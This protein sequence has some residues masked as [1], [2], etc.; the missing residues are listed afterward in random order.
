MNT[1]RSVLWISLLAASLPAQQLNDDLFFAPGKTRVLILSGRNNHDWRAST[2]HLRRILEA[3]GRFD[4]RVTEEP[5]AL[6]RE[7]LRPYHVLVSDYCGPR[8]SA[9]AEDA[10]ASFVRGGKGLV[11][12]HAA[13]YPFGVMPVL[14]SNM[15]RTDVIQPAWEEWDKML[16]AR[17]Q[18]GDPA[19]GGKRT[20]HSRRH[21]FTVE[22]TDTAHPI[23]AG[24]PPSFKVSDELYSRFVLAPS[25][26]ILARAFDSPEV[27]GTGE[28]EP[29]LW[30]NPYG[31]GRVFH[32]ALGHDVPAMMA[33]GFIDSF[34][35]GVEWAATGSVTLP[36]LL[37]LEPKAQDALRV[38]LVTGGHDHDPSLYRV[39]ESHPSLRVNV[40]PHPA[41]FRG[42]LRKRYDVVV[43]Y[44]MNQ[45]LT[46][47]Q[48]KNLRD[49]AEAGKGLI[50]LHHALANYQDWPWWREMA[51][52][53]YLLNDRAD[54]NAKGSTYKHD[55]D[56]E[57]RPSGNHPIV[58]GL[59]P[60]WIRDETYRGVWQAPGIQPFL[61]TDEATSDRVIGWV[62]P[63][64]P[65]RVAVIQLGHGREAHENPWFQRLLRN[66]ILWSGGRLN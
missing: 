32:T 29:M 39:F 35:R 56:L 61:T 41:A 31:Q 14:T 23:A 16:G 13:S 7:T 50:V 11:A 62:S 63:Y 53:L 51:G 52:G 33:Q 19:H 49:F 27:N 65:A 15:G 66:A 48:R 47:A 57:A 59:P 24:L 1:M 43:M 26:R 40:D 42:D 5:S 9:A 18:N 21:V 4:V 3:T 10:V 25:I 58:R 54:L 34:A 60:M 28:R 22:W 55:V 30:T 46:D 17:W 37:S 38:L 44:D 8:W 20:G 45:T 2:A 36:P 64:R 6:T 12:V